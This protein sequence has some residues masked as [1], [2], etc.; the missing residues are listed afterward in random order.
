M[1]D[2]ARNSSAD[3]IVLVQDGTGALVSPFGRLGFGPQDLLIIPRGTT[4]QWQL[5]S[6]SA[7]LLSMES[8]EPIEVPPKLRN[9][10]GQ[11][12]ERSL[13]CERDLR[14]PELSE[15]TVG[16]GRYRV[17]VQHGTGRTE[18]TL[19]QHPFDVIGWDGYLF[20]YALNLA[21]VEPITGSLHQMPDVYQILGTAGTVICVVPPHKLDYHPLAIPSP[22]SHNNVDSDEVM[23]T[24]SGLVPGRTTGHAGHL[25]FHPRGITHGPK[26]GAYEASIGAHETD[27]T[28]FMIDTFA[29]L[30]PTSAAAAVEDNSYYREWLPQ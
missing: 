6:P 1:N 20:P 21:D 15:P 27:L 2:F 23:F 14:V 7:R 16:S 5:D 19:D 12:L 28:A 26:A 30:K 13:Y 25:T 24:V 11:L 9:E 22:P 4:V 18:V 29:T 8:S 3:E 10:Y 17:L